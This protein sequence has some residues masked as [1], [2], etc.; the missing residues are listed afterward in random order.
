MRDQETGSGQRRT[1][2]LELHS[3]KVALDPLAFSLDLV[4]KQ[5]LL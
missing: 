4:G 2:V 1:A 5:A 3:W